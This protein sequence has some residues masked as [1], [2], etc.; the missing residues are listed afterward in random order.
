MLDLLMHR[1]KNRDFNLTILTVLL[2][3][4]M[5][6]VFIR[7]A[8]YSISK[9][10]YGNF[11]LLQTA[12]AGLSSLFLQIPGQ[13][14]DRF[15]N[16]SRNKTVFINEFRTL[17]IA[18]NLL[19]I[20][21]VIIYGMIID[22][23]FAETLLLL[24]LSFVLINN[25]TLNQKVFLLNLDRKKY[26]YLKVAEGV[27]KFI[28]PIVFY[29][30]WQSLHALLYGILIGYVVA[31]V[32]LILFL[33][34]HPFSFTINLP[35]FK[36]YFYF[37]YPTIFLSVITW[38]LSFSDRYFI[39]Y[40]MGT[41]DV[42]VYSLLAMVAGVG[43]IVGQ[44]YFMYIE[45]KVYREYEENPS[46]TLLDLAGYLKKL[47]VVFVI[48]T[49]I[50]FLLPKQIYTILL[51]QEIV[52]DSYYFTTM[53]ILL[54]AIFLNVLH[55]AHHMYFKLFKRLDLLGYVYAVAL[56][57]NLL[58]NLFIQKYGIM[59]AAFSTVAAYLTILLLQSIVIKYYFKKKN[60][61]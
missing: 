1:L 23:F 37:A 58:G 43:Q 14:F 41:Q 17:L 26:F 46:K 53:M 27:A 61:I 21:V 50:A 49:V 7:Y 10:D 47:F 31:Y 51:E 15:Y 52:N 60:L 19:S 39:E 35:N 30:V 38:G 45:P 29:M 2:T 59:A 24:Y 20:P 25:Y 18:I 6:F 8:S 3:V 33:R 28:I 11:V 32:L 5:Q 40:Y 9:I 55:V 12:I 13:A 48:L 56:V 57:V 36:K 42:A 4:L 34:D 54:G 22:K 16:A 44:I